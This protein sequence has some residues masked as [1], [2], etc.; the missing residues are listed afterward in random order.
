[1]TS[2]DAPRI[3]ANLPTPLVGV[4]ERVIIAVWM[5]WLVVLAVRLLRRPWPSVQR[6]LP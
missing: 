6:T 3:Q 4:W 1:V 2:V 5:V